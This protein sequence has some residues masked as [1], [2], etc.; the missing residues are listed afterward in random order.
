MLTGRKKL[1]KTSETPGKTQLINHFNINDK[2]NLVDLPGYGFAKASKS[3]KE[4]WHKMTEKY[5]MERSNLLNIFV[6][7]DSRH[8]PQKNDEEFIRS[9]GT[10]SIPFA[11]CFTK[12]DKL[13][14]SKVEANIKNYCD[15]LL[16]QWEELPKMFYTSSKTGK[17][18]QELLD[19][20]DETNKVFKKPY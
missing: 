16:Q 11:I 7:I 5:I 12:M 10:S 15:H 17:G 1:A 9:L 18:K 20:I 14:K 4:I 2:W 6:L 13:K 19:F 3:A 8:S